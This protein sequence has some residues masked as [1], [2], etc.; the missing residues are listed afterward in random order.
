MV[1]ADPAPPQSPPV[2]STYLQR[3]FDEVAF[4]D[5]VAPEDSRGALLRALDGIR[6]CLNVIFCHGA[7][8]ATPTLTLAVSLRANAQAEP[9]VRSSSGLTPENLRMVATCFRAYPFWN[10]L[11]PVEFSVTAWRKRVVE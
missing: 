9:V 8:G 1:L 10:Q 2:D 3:E 5:L 11:E 7:P 6:P 4:G